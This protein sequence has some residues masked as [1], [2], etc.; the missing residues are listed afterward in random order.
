[1]SDKPQADE[2]TLRKMQELLRKPPKQRSEMKLGKHE[3]NKVAS[4][5]RLR[6]KSQLKF[7]SFQ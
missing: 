4:P 6:R 3:S 7:L 1:M 2:N 5:K